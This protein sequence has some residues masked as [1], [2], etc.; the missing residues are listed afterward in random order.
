MM[1][2]LTAAVARYRAMAGFIKK[3]PP[4]AA[5]RA[6]EDRKR[7][8]ADYVLVRRDRALCEPVRM[9]RFL[10]DVCGLTMQEASRAVRAAL[11]SNQCGAWPAA[12]SVDGLVAE[13]YRRTGAMPDAMSMARFLGWASDAPQ[14]WETV[15]VKLSAMPVT[16][17]A[18]GIENW[19]DAAE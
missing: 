9:V 18:T 8:A 14:I 10:V 19:Q 6:R 5:R 7:Y 2:K 16:R 1:D 11:R 13:I 3:L 4:K 15:R 12:K 17:E